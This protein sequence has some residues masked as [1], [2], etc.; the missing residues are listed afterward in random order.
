M[1]DIAKSLGRL[2]PDAAVLNQHVIRI[3]FWWS[4]SQ[5]SHIIIHP[6]SNLITIKPTKSLLRP[7]L[8]TFGGVLGAQNDGLPYL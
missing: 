4:R 2:P 5:T 1:N 7:G 3:S 8:G 6:R